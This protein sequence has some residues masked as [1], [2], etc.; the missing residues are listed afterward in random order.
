MDSTLR[1]WEA[2]LGDRPADSDAWSRHT[3]AALQSL[4]AER[5]S[6][7]AAELRMPEDSLMP[8][9]AMRNA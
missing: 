6:A 1:S 4:V 5:D 7:P 8:A 9:E 2:P 3:I